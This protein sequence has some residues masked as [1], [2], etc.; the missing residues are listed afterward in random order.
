MVCWTTLGCAP[1]FGVDDCVVFDQALV[2]AV[3]A[4]S[5]TSIDSGSR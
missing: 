4:P 2:E 5:T 1:R 3:G